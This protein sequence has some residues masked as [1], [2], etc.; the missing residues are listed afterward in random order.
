MILLEVIQ[1]VM[2]VAILRLLWVIG[3]VLNDEILPKM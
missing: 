2:I 1:T 3:K